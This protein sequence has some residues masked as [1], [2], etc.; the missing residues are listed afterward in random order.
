MPSRRII[1]LAAALTVAVAAGVAFT[2]R[3]DAHG[4]FRFENFEGFLGLGPADEFAATKTFLE[5]F[6]IG[7]PLS[8]I[9]AFFTQIGG[10]CVQMPL[11]YPGRIVCIYG[12]SIVPWI[13]LPVGF[14]WS[15]DV[16]Y[17]DDGNTLS[18]VELSGGLDGP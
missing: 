16:L 12:H 8:E 2:L 17:G 18:A 9:E 4:P 1:V 15:V 3:T 6:P 7:T 13:P 10:E 11:D 5:K 14:L